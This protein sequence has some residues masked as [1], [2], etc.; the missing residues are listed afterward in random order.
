MIKTACLVENRNRICLFWI[1]LS[2][3]DF[4]YHVASHLLCKLLLFKTLNLRPLSTRR[5]ANHST[6]DGDG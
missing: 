1:K 4:P 2:L 5:D 3:P 6:F